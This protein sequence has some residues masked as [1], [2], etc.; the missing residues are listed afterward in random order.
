MSRSGCCNELQRNDQRVKKTSKDRATSRGGVVVKVILCQFCAGTGFWPKKSQR[1]RCEFCG[2]SGLTSAPENLTSILHDPK[3]WW[4]RAEEVRSLADDMRDETSKSMM[5]R[6][7]EGYEQIATRIENRL[8]PRSA[9]D[10]T[11]STKF[12]WNGL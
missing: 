8:R 12:P 1:V 11:S 7:A 10:E 6:I 3:H 2:G 5:L 9:K 4:N